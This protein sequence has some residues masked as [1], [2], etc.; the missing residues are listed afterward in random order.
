MN[1]AADHIPEFLR[2][3]E[4]MIANAPDGPEESTEAKRPARDISYPTGVPKR[5]RPEWDRPTD[6]A[7]SD[8]FGKVMKGVSAGGIVG[9]IGKRG[10]GKTRLA[11]EAIRSHAPDSST[12]TTAMGLFLR[13]Q[14]TYGTDKT[15]S[16]GD[17]VGELSQCT[18]LVIDEVQE[19][20]NTP[21]EDRLLTHIIDKRYGAKLPTVIIANLEAAAMKQCLGDSISSRINETGGIIEITGKSFRE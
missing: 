11:A 13:I 3:L 10:T 20:G 18:T 8:N 6:T 21:W 16:T 19:R 2:D 12:Y 15:E 14:S 17:I 4:E 7:W 5:Y 9:L 1:Q